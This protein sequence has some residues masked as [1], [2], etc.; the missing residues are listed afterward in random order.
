MV[1]SPTRSSSQK[2]QHWE[3]FKTEYSICCNSGVAEAVAW[4]ICHLYY[5][6]YPTDQ[7]EEEVLFVIHHYVLVI[8]IKKITK[9]NNK[10]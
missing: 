10:K 5:Y 4:F 8:I 7:D 3:F 2:S 1:I 6:Y 9:N